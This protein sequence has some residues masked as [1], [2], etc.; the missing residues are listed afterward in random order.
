M[1]KTT[2]LLL[3]LSSWFLHANI[4]MDLRQ[5][6]LNMG[7]DF[8]VIFVNVNISSNSNGSVIY[9][10]YQNI[11]KSS[12]CKDV[13]F[14]FRR[15]NYSQAYY[16]KYMREVMKIDSFPK[17][18]ARICISDDIYNKYKKYGWYSEVL[19]FSGSIRY[20]TPAKFIDLK[21]VK[22]LP[23]TRVTLNFRGKTLLDTN[24]LHT[25]RD[26]FV[27]QNRNIVQVSDNNYRLCIND[28][29]GRSEHCVKLSQA[30]TPLELYRNYL[31]PSAEDLDIA[32]KYNNYKR[33]NRPEIT[34][35]NL[36]A[37]SSYIYVPVTVAINE[38]RK[39]TRE[40]SGGGNFK[41]T[42]RKGEVDGNLFM[43]LFR[44]DTTLSA[45]TVIDLNQPLT[46]K[47]YKND[48][49][50]FQDIY[51]FNDTLFFICHDY[52]KEYRRKW[53]CKRVVSSFR[54]NSENRLVFEKNYRI[55]PLPE[56]DYLTLTNFITP[57]NGD[58]IFTRGQDIYS[59]GS[60]KLVAKLSGLGKNKGRKSTY[61]RFIDDTTRYNMAFEVLAVDNLDNHYMVVVYKNFGTV[62]YEVFD[63]DLHS[64]Q[65][66]PA[67]I[68]DDNQVSGY[69]TY[70]HELMQLKF[71]NGRA[72]LLQYALKVKKT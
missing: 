52:T 63:K 55:P 5:Y 19:Y 4:Q 59:L 14:L 54:L 47:L 69:F 25:R 10:I 34:P 30:E 20:H 46:D 41:K 48:Y 68:D 31:H 57:F 6:G 66:S 2:L 17:R 43:F 61:P 26:L 53:Y 29:E 13:V 37:S 39:Y 58:Y 22:S 67:G 72:Y 49:L 24:Y 1:K 44:Y 50:S 7:E 45:H 71:S 56:S 51:T 12:D 18:H 16:I 42:F 64:V 8:Y 35:Q 40:Y 32:V 15:E 21:K 28:R 65:L 11:Q 9:T 27:Q 33:I 70:N 36:F 38:R 60:E 62:L 23:V 3:F